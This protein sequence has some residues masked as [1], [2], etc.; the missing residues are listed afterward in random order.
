MFKTTV[1]L[2]AYFEGFRD[3]AYK[4]TPHDKW[5]V[6]FGFTTFYGKQVTEGLMIDRLDAEAY[7]GRLC[8]Q[9]SSSLGAYYGDKYFKLAANQKMAL[10]SFCYNIGYTAFIKSSIGVLVS[11]DLLK[12]IPFHMLLWVHGPGGDIAP[13]LKTRR[14]IEAA[15]FEGKPYEQF[16]GKSLA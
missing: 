7:L 4:P 10:V 12:E 3:K 14:Q 6:G 5:T 16:L 1:D 9:F 15:I 11:H 8:D 13:G 2:V